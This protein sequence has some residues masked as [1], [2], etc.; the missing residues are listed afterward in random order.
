MGRL[1]GRGTHTTSE[2]ERAMLTARLYRLCWM[3]LMTYDLSC[4]L[5]AWRIAWL[6]AFCRGETA[7]A[8]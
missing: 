4:R 8:G 2:G 3:D 5:L 6:Q 7:Y 1:P